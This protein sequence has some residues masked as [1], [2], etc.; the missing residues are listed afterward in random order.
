[1]FIFD[2]TDK[3]SRSPRSTG[4]VS[5]ASGAT[6]GVRRDA[7]GRVRQ[8]SGCT[9]PA[10]PDQ[11][12][13]A[14]CFCNAVCVPLRATPP[15]RV[16]PS[17]SGWLT[18]ARVAALEWLADSAHVRRAVSR[19][20]AEGCSACCLSLYRRCHPSCVRRG[21]TGRQPSYSGQGHCEAAGAPE[22]EAALCACLATVHA[23]RYRSPY[24]APWPSFLEPGSAGPLGMPR[25][26]RAVTHMTNS[27][28][29]TDETKQT[30]AIILA[31]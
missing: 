3:N 17:R 6:P 11:E 2:G 8:R 1:M 22:E 19:P 29:L 12:R 15:P 25:A 9:L 20:A 4:A 26:A 7:D 30:L 24:W 23:R 16:A 14:D 18:G 13:Y 5:H 10:A 21:C 28:H 31:R 27:H